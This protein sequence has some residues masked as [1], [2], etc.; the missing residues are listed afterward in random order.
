LY[1]PP[2]PTNAIDM[3]IGVDHLFWTDASGDVLRSSLEGDSPTVIDS[4]GDRTLGLTADDSNV[5]W[6]QQTQGTL[7]EA[8]RDGEGAAVLATFEGTP[9]ELVVA[10]AKQL[11]VVLSDSGEIWSV[12]RS[13]GQTALV[14]TSSPGAAFLA[15]DADYLAWTDVMGGK[16][17]MMTRASGEV[18]VAAANQKQPQ[19][20]AIRDGTLYWTDAG[21]AGMA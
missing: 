1:Q 3:T 13:D 9:F 18:S 6:L 8:D 4:H 15:A 12:E 16:V 17:S 11:F 7:T 10:D 19:G 20:I 2:K 21:A 14:A 5:Y